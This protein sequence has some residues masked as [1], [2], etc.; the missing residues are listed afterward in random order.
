M[1]ISIILGPLQAASALEIIEDRLEACRE[2]LRFFNNGLFFVKEVEIWVGA[3]SEA[4]G[5]TKKGAF[6]SNNF[7]E[8]TEYAY[9]IIM[10]LDFSDALN[11]LIIFRGVWEIEE[12]KLAGYFSVQNEKERRK[13]YGDLEISAYPQGSIRDLVD[14]LWKLNYVDN[15]VKDFLKEFQMNIASLKIRLSRAVFSHGLYSKSDPS[16]I[17]AIYLTGNRRNLLGLF[18]DALKKNEDP[19]ISK[20]ASPIDTNFFLDTLSENELVN[21]RIS[22]RLDEAFVTEIPVHSVLYIAKD[23]QSFGNLFGEITKAVMKPAFSKLLPEVEVKKRIT[24]GLEE[25]K[26]EN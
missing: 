8:T 21:E 12:T 4:L 1:A 5:G 17:M 22:K 26:E 7:L 18:Y 6:A 11:S 14:A 15:L 3:P 2:A 13:A 16:G 23:P 19:E 24:E 10:E 20:K 25:F 9:K